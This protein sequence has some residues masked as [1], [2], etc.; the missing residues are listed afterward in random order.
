ALEG[1]GF[2]FASTTD[3]SDIV[4][5][6]AVIRTTPA[7]GEMAPK[8]S[9]ITAIVSKGP[10]LFAMPDLVGLSLSAAKAKAR[11]AGLVVRNEYPVP[12]SGK[13]QGTVQGQNPTSGTMVRRGTSIDLYY[14]N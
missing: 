4:P 8:G 10:R 9:T 7:G 14:A 2:T 1:A 12:G 6:G 5:E 3:F 13:A 11:N